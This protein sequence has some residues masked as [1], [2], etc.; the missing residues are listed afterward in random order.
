MSHATDP[1]RDAARERA[2][3]RVQA[4]SGALFALF[5]LAHLA[6]Q[7][8]AAAGPEVYDEL[9][10]QLRA[11][12]QAPLVELACV[13]GPLVVHV[14]VSVWRM[15]RRRRRGQKPAGNPRA[16][17]QRITAI[18]LLVFVFGHTLAT[19]GASLVYGVYPGFDG[20]AYTLV[21]AFAYFFPYYLL[22][23]LAGLY[24]GLNGLALALPRIGLRGP[25]ALRSGRAVAGAWLAGAVA[26]T[27]GMAGLAGAF[28]DVR[29]RAVASPYARLLVDLGVSSGPAAPSQP[30]R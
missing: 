18:V 1:S 16:R 2:L 9:Q 6:N 25:A 22:F 10:G 11:A 19:R 12:Y 21:W 23:S 14:V 27:L 8:F 17:W 3:I 26:L 4:A 24:H 13:L 29:E 15:A 5:L 28:H 20:V 7:M 30:A